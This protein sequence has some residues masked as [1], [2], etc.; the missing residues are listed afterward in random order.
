MYTE[1]QEAITEELNTRLNAFKNGIEEEKKYQKHR[2]SKPFEMTYKHE[3]HIGG[4]N[5]LMNTAKTAID[6]GYEIPRKLSSLLLEHM[7]SRINGADEWKVVT[8]LQKS[9]LDKFIYREHD[10]YTRSVAWIIEGHKEAMIVK[11]D[12]P[13]ASFSGKIEDCSFYSQ[14]YDMSAKY[15]G[16]KLGF[17]K[18]KIYLADFYKYF[19]DSAGE[20]PPESSTIKDKINNLKGVR[21]MIDFYISELKILSLKL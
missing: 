4:F 13:K 14:K 20:N 16:Y 5:G 18:T 10:E 9:D 15:Y 11:Q 3:W 21:T 17:D 12:N 7:I 1:S 6:A 19:L 2:G 8:D